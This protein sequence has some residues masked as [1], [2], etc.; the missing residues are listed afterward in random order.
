M[1]LSFQIHYHTIWG[2]AVYVCG[3][4]SELGNWE[5]TKAFRLSSQGGGIWKGEIEIADS[6]E[7]NKE[8]NFEYKYFLFEENNQNR[9]WEFGENRKSRISKNIA[10][11]ALHDHWNPLQ[12]E[13]NALFT[14]AFTEVLLRHNPDP[15][16]KKT[17]TKEKEEKIEK[18]TKVRFQI[19]APRVGVKYRLCLLGNDE[20]V[21]NWDTKKA[22]QLKTYH[23]PLWEAEVELKN[24]NETI[25]YKYGIYDPETQTVKTWEEGDNRVLKLPD[26][27][28]NSLYVKTD[29]KFRYP[30]GNWKGAGLAIPVFALRSKNGLGVGE[31]ADLKLLVDWA[32][33]TGMKMI[34][35]LPINDTVATHTWKDSYPYAAISVFALHPIYLNLQGIGNLSASLTQ[36]IIDEQR[37]WLNEKET[38][39]YEG[40]MRIK[41]RF[42]KLAYDEQRN[43]FL[44]EKEFQTF[45][46]ENK[47]WLKP[48]AAF[49]YLR[50]LYGTYNYEKWGRFA[51]YTPEL[52]DEVT[53]PKGSQYD[54]IAV[55][56]FIQYHLHRQLLDAYQYAKAKQVV[57]KGDIPIGIFRYSVDAWVSPELYNLES[58]AG[59]PPD[60]FAATGQNWKFP[61]YNWGLMAQDNYAWWR[62]RLAHLSHYFDAFRIDHILGFFRIWEIDGNAVEGI[63]GQF[64][65]SMAFGKSELQG[66]GI[67]FDYERFCEPFIRRHTLRNIVG[68]ETDYVIN[69]FLNEPRSGHY[70][71][72]PEF[73]TQK[74]IEAYFEKQNEEAGIEQIARNMRLKEGLFRLAAE[75]IFLEAPF[76]N[77]EAFNPRHTFQKT[78]SYQYLSESAKQILNDLYIDYFYKRHEIFWKEQAM[79][80]LPAITKATNM[81]VCGEDLGMVPDCVP[82]TMQELGILSLNIQRMPKDPK[83]E[84]GHPSDY[85]YLSVGTPSSHDMSTIRGWW[86]E[87]KAQIQEFYN[88]I[89]GHGG[90]APYFCEA[91]IVREIIVQHLYSP[92]MWVVF[93]IQDLLGM[94]T[95]LRR[96]NA[97]AEQINVPANPNHYWRY[98]LHLNIEDLLLADDF[99]TDLAELVASSG[100]SAEY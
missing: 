35:I 64:N 57:L 62:Q 28:E 55:H 38:V 25:T 65:P 92:C 18:T 53:N 13:E 70:K 2:Q 66:R 94:D 7:P 96:E 50:D 83:R 95:K 44:K 45:F 98:R 39:D 30:L 77:G 93:P 8:L 21:G 19:F 61:T 47:T 91:W 82:P 100:R 22:V 36:E 99:N 43:I 37:G 49:S 68:E 9:I 80:K 84:F 3:S 54:D 23:F 42:F 63:L 16:P 90:D 12:D 51:K 97:K 56:Y 27:A 74:L 34:Q 32:V 15:L 85:P 78:Q 69:T 6:K 87:D 48:Y 5:N 88:Q 20:A 89:M 75:V 71:F 58:Q 41:S 26:L 29:R 10:H 31:F 76:S 1:K 67:Q 14:S 33:K 52:I 4:L 17:A 24:P 81:L 73:K 79:N 59:A 46:E 72:K 40:V 11:V 86:E 60:D